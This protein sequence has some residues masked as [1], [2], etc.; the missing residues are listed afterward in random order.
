MQ[1][2][3][4]RFILILLFILFQACSALPAGGSSPEPI[5]KSSLPSTNDSKSLLNGRVLV[6]IW[7]EGRHSAFSYTFD[8]GLDCHY[9]TVGP[10]MKAYGFKGTFYVITGLMSSQQWHFGTWQGFKSLL[11]EGHEIGSH[12][13]THPYLTK[14][15]TGSGTQTNTALYEI[16]HSKSE[17]EQHYPGYRCLTFSYPYSDLNQNIKTLISSNYISARGDGN[18]TEYNLFWNQQTPSPSQFSELVSIVPIFPT[19]R[20]SVNDD[21]P[22]LQRNKKLIATSIT[23]G[24]WACIMAHAV[25][26][27]NIISTYGGFQTMSTSWFKALCDFMKEHS[28]QKMVWIDTVLNITRYIRER[29]AVQAA[30]LTDT[31]N[32]LELSLTD[33]LDDTIYNIPLTLDINIP[34]E[35]SN[36]NIQQ[37]AHALN[38]IRFN[39]GAL[40]YIRLEALPDN[41]TIKIQ[42]N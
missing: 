34:N 1:Y 16:V 5:I 8:D 30:I 17:I 3:P 39:D 41:G 18:L 21:L 2:Y 19:N 15:S 23:N 7:S 11:D 38:S 29:E 13:V 6:K 36:I 4:T 42:N 20:N 35:W 22:E 27:F 31:S 40:S 12:T 9:D 10:I 37:G 24:T 33:N 28:D 25:V 14:L 32:L 26:P